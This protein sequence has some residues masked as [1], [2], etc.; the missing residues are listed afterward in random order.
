LISKN[1]LATGLFLTSLFSIGCGSADPDME[2][3]NEAIE[4]LNAPRASTASKQYAVELLQST[5]DTGIAAIEAALSEPKARNRDGLISALGQLGPAALPVMEKL[6]ANEE[7]FV[8]TQTLSALASQQADGVPLLAKSL[9]KYPEHR[10]AA[11]QALAKIGPDASPASEEIAQCL[12]VD[13]DYVILQASEALKSIG[14]AASSAVPILKEQLATEKDRNRRFNIVRAY[15]A[16]A[17]GDA[18]DDVASYFSSEDGAG[19]AVTI[20]DMVGADAVPGL[21]RALENSDAEIRLQASFCLSWIGE[22]KSSAIR[23][24]LPQIK[25]CLTEEK[26]THVRGQM[27]LLIEKFE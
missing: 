22:K 17:G 16:V 26:D 2:K 4:L 10:G 19:Y 12:L 13:D 27:E 6:L 14:P 9:K 23:A 8:V 25:A 15:L 11:L 1:T 20:S 18:I 5:G 7:D 21:L 3:A 24:V